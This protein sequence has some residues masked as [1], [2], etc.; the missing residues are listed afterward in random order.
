VPRRGSLS[1]PGAARESASRRGKSGP[2]G[3]SPRRHLCRSIPLNLD[4]AQISLTPAL[5]FTAHLTSQPLHTHRKS[6]TALR[7]CAHKLQVAQT[8]THACARAH[9]HTHTTCMRCGGAVES[10]RE[11]DC[12]SGPPLPLLRIGRRMSRLTSGTFQKLRYASCGFT[13]RATPTPSTPA[14]WNVSAARQP[15]RRH[16]AV[17]LQVA[18][19][20]ASEQSPWRG[21]AWQ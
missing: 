15:W 14:A 4:L 16:A 10:E 18:K 21:A 17:T 1:H 6:K 12:F 13:S 5:G 3:N 9:T 2:A 8:R 20:G 19:T 7:A 11:S